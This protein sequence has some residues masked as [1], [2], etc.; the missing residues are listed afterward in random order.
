MFKAKIN[1]FLELSHWSTVFTDTEIAIL[2]T[3]LKKIDNYNTQLN[4]K[5]FS[6]IEQL[7]EYTMPIMSEILSEV[8]DFFNNEIDTDFDYPYYLTIR[9]LNDENGDSI[10]IEVDK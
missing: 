9:A 2:R 3:V 6:T 1:S 5:E 7:G 4:D 10:F 8:K